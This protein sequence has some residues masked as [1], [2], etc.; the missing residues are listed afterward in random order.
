MA[1]AIL[2]TIWGWSDAQLCD[3]A[4]LLHWWPTASEIERGVVCAVS[5]AVEHPAWPEAIMAVERTSY[6][7]G[8]NRGKAWVALSHGLKDKHEWAESLWRH[9]YAMKCLHASMPGRLTDHERNLLVELAYI[10]HARRGKRQRG[11]SASL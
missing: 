1:W 11:V 9:L 8:L 4:W 5:K 3:T 7:L 2:S 10:D 6:T